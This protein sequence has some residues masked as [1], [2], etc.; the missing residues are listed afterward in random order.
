MIETPGVMACHR[1]QR[2]GTCRPV[3]SVATPLDLTVVYSL[4]RY[5]SVN[6]GSVLG[7]SRIYGIFSE[8]FVFLEC[9]IYFSFSRPG[10]GE[11]DICPQESPALFVGCVSSK[12]LTSPFIQI[13]P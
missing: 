10:C 13:Y 5:N 4:H 7:L 8:V 6:N 12:H 1:E 2:T 11:E 3:P 9:S